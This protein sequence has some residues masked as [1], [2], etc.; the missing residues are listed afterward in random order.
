LA[1]DERIVL[2]SSAVDLYHVKDE[3]ETGSLSSVVVVGSW[4]RRESDDDQEQELHEEDG[5]HEDS[6]KRKRRRADEERYGMRS[7]A[8]TEVEL[9]MRREVTC[10][11]EEEHE[12]LGL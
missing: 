3:T 4:K 10:C 11:S 7:S 8:E 12:P 6:E 5:M 1:W 2:I 9:R